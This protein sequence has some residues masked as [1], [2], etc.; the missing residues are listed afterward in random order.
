MVK[1]ILLTASFLSFAAAS[2]AWVVA[3]YG[4]CGGIGYTGATICEDPYV[5]TYIIAY[6]SQCLPSS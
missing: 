2:V 6:Y 1:A 4:Q 3:P 5:C